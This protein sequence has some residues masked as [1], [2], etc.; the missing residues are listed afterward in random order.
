MLTLLEQYE[1]GPMT[2]EFMFHLGNP[3]DQAP[4]TVHGINP[5]Y[6]TKR[7]HEYDLLMKF[8]LDTQ[9]M[10]REINKAVFRDMSAADRELNR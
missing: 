6:F 5:S 2:T 10:V 8:P 9:L 4:P 3:A 1:G 7:K